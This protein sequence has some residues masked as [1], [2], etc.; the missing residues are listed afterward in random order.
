MALILA[1]RPA[2][3]ELL[4]ERAERLISC[5]AKGADN[6]H[7]VLDERV[8]I[9]AREPMLQLDVGTRVGKPEEFLGSPQIGA[10]DALNETANALLEV[11]QTA[12]RRAGERHQRANVLARALN[13]LGYLAAELF[14]LLGRILDDL[15]L[16]LGQVVR[17]PANI[18][19]ADPA[20]AIDGLGANFA[21]TAGGIGGE[22]TSASN[23][24]ASSLTADLHGLS[25]LAR[26]I[27]LRVISH[28]FLLWR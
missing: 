7:A 22:L 19:A 24:V 21:N 11:L 8:E 26:R 5:P 16:A 13:S 2:L 18:F 15:L 10:H 17:A 3:L 20:G 1:S 25:R 14:E 27:L 6:R 4:L 28:V 12:P 9:L 23:G